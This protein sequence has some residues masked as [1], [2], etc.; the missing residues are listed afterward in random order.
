MFSEMWK[1]ISA[2]PPG[3]M[4]TTFIQ[5]RHL[6]LT[7]G[8]LLCLGGFLARGEII[9]WPLPGLDQAK[10]KSPVID[11]W[12][13]LHEIFDA[14]KRWSSN[15]G[16]QF[17][18]DFQVFTNEMESPEILFCPADLS[19]VILTNWADVNWTK[20][21][22][23]WIAQTNWN[24]S[25]NICCTCRVH[26]HFLHIDGT[27]DAGR[28]RPGWPAIIAGP[29]GLW[30]SPG[31]D[32]QFRVRV[33]PNAL[34][35]LSYQWRREHLYFVTNVIFHT[36]QLDPAEGYWVTNRVPNFAITNLTFETNDT[37]ELH[38]VQTN[39]AD[40]YSVAVSNSMG[41]T[42]SQAILKVDAE[43]AMMAT[44]EYWSQSN[45]INNLKQVALLASLWRADHDDRMPQN[46]EEMTNSFGSPIFGWPVVLYCRSDKDRTAP[47]DW[48]D[49]DLANTSYEILPTEPE[50]EYAVF[51]RCKIHGFYAQQNG[52]AISHP[53]F[54]GFRASTNNTVDFGIQIFAGKTNLLETSSDL[55][56]WTNLATFSSTNGILSVHETNNASQ[57]FYRLRAQ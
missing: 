6:L 46:L 57:R 1:K 29:S 48:P 10:Q 53:S 37:L 28:E 4:K 15:H 56:T 43:I 25:N 36:N 13:N 42:V 7:C 55:V 47:E 8:I 31:S 34:L 27:V 45:C 54:A 11:C 35:P 49:V 23:T 18:S 3:V 5:L 2:F 19:R 12:R 44:N 52:M 38:N 14:S 22:Y 24:G 50:D 17:P 32:V 20:I 51:C 21:D 39:D 41:T 16:N 9:Y 40:Y 26:T 33:A 30:A